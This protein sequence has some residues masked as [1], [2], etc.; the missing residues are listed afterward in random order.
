MDTG[1]RFAF[2]KIFVENIQAEA[3]FYAAAFGMKEKNRLTVG[4]G[5]DAVE[6][7]ILTSGR[8]DDSSLIVWRYVERPTPPLGESVLGFNVTDIAATVRAVEEAGGTVD[9]PIEEMPDI[10][11]AVVFVKDPEGHLIEI[12]QNL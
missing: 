9:T 12:A 10:G 5:N 4:R 1:T 8:G 6:E 3:D 2:T 7:I 11:F